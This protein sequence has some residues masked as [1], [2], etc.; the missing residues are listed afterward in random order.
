MR[1]N[2]HAV[3]TELEAEIRNFMERLHTHL[4]DRLGPLLALEDEWQQQAARDNAPL[5]LQQASKESGYTPDHLGRLVKAGEIPNAGRANAPRILRK[6]LPRKPGFGLTP[7][8]PRLHGPS[9]RSALQTGGVE[10]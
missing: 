7:M 6:N 9:A 8:G 2:T 3:T 10:R 5:N 4:Q 1:L